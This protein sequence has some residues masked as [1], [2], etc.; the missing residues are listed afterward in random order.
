MAAVFPRRAGTLQNMA[1]NM[2]AYEIQ[3][4]AANACGGPHAFDQTKRQEQQT[5]KN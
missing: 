5:K 3:N 4:C 1:K 2:G